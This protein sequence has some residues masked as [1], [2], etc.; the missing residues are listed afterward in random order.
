LVSWIKTDNQGLLDGNT[1]QNFDL[2]EVTLEKMELLISDILLYSSI[3][4]TTS[5]T[6]NVNLDII[7]KDL[8]KILFIPENISVRVLNKLPIVKGEKTKLQQLFQN[9]I[10]NAIKFNDKEK[11]LIQIDVVENKTFYEFSIKDNGIGIQK[12][13]HDKIF[14]IFNSLKPSKESSGI[15]LSIVKKIVDVYQGEIWIES[16]LKIGT[17]FYFTLKK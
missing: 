13:Y 9:L 4:S 11:G 12:K 8:Q 5:E 16:E 3:A 10:D 15:G 7:L 2:I 6:T 14:K 17:T 1:L